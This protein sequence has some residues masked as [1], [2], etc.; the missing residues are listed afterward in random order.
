M[1]V[2]FIILVL[3]FFI[4]SSAQSQ[5]SIKSILIIGDSYLKGHLGAFL[6]K[7]MHEKGKYDI[8]S[9]AI[10]G[11]GSKTFLPP[12]KNKCCGYRVRQT[13]AGMTLNK[14]KKVTEV[15]I[16]ILERAEKPTTGTVMN[17]FKGDLNLIMDMYKPDATI[18]ILGA[19]NINAHEEL[20]AIIKSYDN[21]NPIIWIGPFNTKNSASRYSSIENALNK[22]ND[23]LLV[24]SDTIVS[25]LKIKPSHFYGSEAKKLAKALFQQFESFLTSSIT[26][27]NKIIWNDFIFQ[28]PD[29]IKQ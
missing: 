17:L 21:Y 11:A 3:F 20:L 27:K 24:K 22:Y 14:T 4:S 10:G 1:R 25:N 18:L 28:L 13:C 29:C 5:T 23:C 19:N 2:R 8:L 15:K 16:P 12:M 26:A 7:E 6:Q 9:I